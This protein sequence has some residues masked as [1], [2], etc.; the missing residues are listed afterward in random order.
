MNARERIASFL[1]NG[2]NRTKWLNN[3]IDEGL[4]YFLGPTGIP[5]RLNAAAELNP[6][7]DIY[8][9][10]A[11]AR[12]GD[13]A[14]AAINTA[15]ALMPV[16]GA[17]LA[18]GGLA[19][20]AA[21]V[22][23][24][25]LTNV[26]TKAAGVADAGQRFAADEFGGVGR[27]KGITAYHGSPHDFEPVVLLEMPDGVQVYQ[28]LLER[29][30]IPE[31][32][33][34][35]KE[36]PLG[37]FSMDAIGTGE[38]AQAYG[39]GLYFAE[40]EKVAREY[41]DALA[42]NHLDT[43]RDPPL[44][45]ALDRKPAQYIGADTQRAIARNG[46][47]EI[48]ERLKTIKREVAELEKQAAD[49]PDLAPVIDGMIASYDGEIGEL[50][51][52]LLKGHSNNY[53]YGG[54][55]YEVRINADP[56][57][58]L[59]WDAPLSEQSAKVREALARS[60]PDTYSPDGGDYDPTEL[61]QITYNRMVGANGRIGSSLPPDRLTSEWMNADGIPGIKYR[62]AGSR[63]TDGGTRNFVVF[64]ENLIEIV[65]KYGIAG[66]A[67]LTGLSAAEVEAG[68]QQANQAQAQ[69][70]RNRGVQ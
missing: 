66:A 6:V 3:T 25:T 23:S 15:S 36:Y 50:N 9:A 1:A 41:R 47:G 7:Q 61:G 4:D 48:K 22:I 26:G 35:L 55:M 56:D 60:D 58:F 14:G 20:D 68:V 38:G 67:A 64:D 12:D 45:D 21:N 17:K 46:P 34:I 59:D 44:F 28:N 31:G 18:G 30:A 10:G 19:D 43:F 27:S 33:K 8:Q 39:H 69:A 32:A 49:E 5:D 29:D 54:R 2:Q 63:G 11:N 62:D 52:I 51:Q 40:N 65:R 70:I 53:P 16:A 37:R 42:A 13:Y 57:D 24:D